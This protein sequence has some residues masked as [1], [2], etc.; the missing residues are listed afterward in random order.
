MAGIVNVVLTPSAVPK[1]NAQPPQPAAEAPTPNPEIDPAPITL[2]VGGWSDHDLYSK[3]AQKTF[4]RGDEQNLPRLSNQLMQAMDQGP[5]VQNLSQSLIDFLQGGQTSVHQGIDRYTYPDL[6]GNWAEPNFTEVESHT[7]LA[8]SELS[9]S[10]TTKSGD[11]LT[12]N[13]HYEK[14]RGHTQRYS[15]IGYETVSIDFELDGRLSQAEQDELMTL[16]DKLNALANDYFATGNIDLNRLD[17]GE[18][19]QLADLSLTLDGGMAEITPAFFLG[20]DHI[21]YGLTLRF[22]DSAETRHL[23]AIV[24]ENRVSMDVDKLG[25]VDGYNLERREAA[26]ANYRQ[27]LIDGVGRVRGTDEQT[28]LLLATFDA[29]HGELEEPKPGLAL[30]DTEAALLTSVADFRLSFYSR[31]GSWAQQ[32]DR[33]ER[34]ARFSLDFAQETQVSQYEGGDRD[35]EQ[36]QLWKLNGSYFR[37]AV[38]DTLPGPSPGDKDHRSY[39]QREDVESRVQIERR[40][41]VV[42]RAQQETTLDATLEEILTQG[43]N[44]LAWNTIAHSLKEHT[45]LLTLL[46]QNADD[47]PLALLG[48]LMLGIEALYERAKENITENDATKAPEYLLGG[49]PVAFANSASSIDPD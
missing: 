36:N 17:I 47:S 18:L 29:L 13:L 9:F 14:G 28:D 27:M 37:P 15:D 45:N 41:G 32:D 40:G 43:E 42:V 26:L 23:E 35:I 31:I 21:D 8:K 34:S 24:N 7:V 6:S 48:E 44:E 33:K 49:Q 25:L 11:T 12:F 38:H 1:I 30:S 2:Q 46:S 16:A 39:Y 5:S 10:L 20:V 19:S 4:M 22:S 3:P